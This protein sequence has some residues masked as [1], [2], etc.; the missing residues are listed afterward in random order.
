LAHIHATEF[1]HNNPQLISE[2]S[3][4]FLEL[5][6]YIGYSTIRLASQLSNHGRYLF[7][8]NNNDYI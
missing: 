2:Y 7:I 8:S 3:E 5:G 1:Q 6:S 4:V